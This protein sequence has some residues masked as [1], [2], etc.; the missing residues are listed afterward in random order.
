MNCLYCGKVFNPVR[1]TAKFCTN[2]CRVYYC[3]KIKVNKKDLDNIDRATEI[4]EKKYRATVPQPILKTPE[5]N[6]VK[7]MKSKF[8]ICPKHNSMYFTCGCT[9]KSEKVE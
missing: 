5:K 1:K 4:I 6:K 2:K 3:R 8:D 7:K 9:P